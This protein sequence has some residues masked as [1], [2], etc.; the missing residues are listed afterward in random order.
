MPHSGGV[1]T[2]APSQHVSSPRGSGARRTWSP[3][4]LAGA[5]AQALALA[6]VYHVC[7][8]TATGQ[9]HENRLHAQTLG[10]RG[11]ATGWLRR[12]L[13]LVEGLQPQHLVL[14]A[15]LV[16]V[17]GLLRGRPGRAVQGLVVAGAT[18]GLT[19]V[20]K[21]VLLER[22]DLSGYAATAN[23]LPSGHSS[24]VLGLVLGAQVAAPS[25][26]RLPLALSA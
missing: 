16:G 15:V 11:S 23:S 25:W 19:E 14:G 6:V 9:L 3:A 8:R 12:A 1:V 17:L 7:V 18:L 4:A 22:P 24:A 26:L 10:T 2:S 20:L 21:L 5:G 13:D